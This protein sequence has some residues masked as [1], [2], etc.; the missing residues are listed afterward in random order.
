MEKWGSQVPW[1]PGYRQ[2]LRDENLDAVLISS[3]HAMHYQQARLALEKGLH[4]LVEKPL[5]I[6]PR[7]TRSL[8]DLA[9]KHRRI[10]QVSYQRHYYAPHVCVRE[11]VQKGAIGELRGVIAYVTQWWAGVGG[12]RLDPKIA[13]GGM[14]FDT[15]SHLVASTLWISSL[16]PAEV[17]AFIDNAG[18]K[19]DINAVVSVRFKGGALGTI[20]TIGNAGRHDERIAFHGST[21]CIVIHLHQWRVRTILHNDEPI[22]IPSRIKETSPDRVFFGWIRNGGRGYSPPYFALQVARLSEAAYRSARLHRP[23]RV[24]R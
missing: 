24:A 14:L 23:V 6:S 9:E 22:Q 10:L 11:M 21:G 7:Q 19:V 20:N 1:Y 13:G 5:T 17:S 12:W 8:I 3:P 4:V 15:G 16:E 2:M 18:K